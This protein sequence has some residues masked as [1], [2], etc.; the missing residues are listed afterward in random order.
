MHG[1]GPHPTMQ[2][3]NRHAAIAWPGP[4][5]RTVILAVVK[6]FA[7]SEIGDPGAVVSGDQHVPA[8]K[9]AVHVCDVREPSRRRAIG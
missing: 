8:R 4:T 2:H 3:G 7:Q 1:R 9:V 5:Y 6:H